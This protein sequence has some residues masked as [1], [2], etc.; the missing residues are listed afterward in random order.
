MADSF[1]GSFVREHAQMVAQYRRMADC[2]MVQFVI[3]RL[4]LVIGSAALP[5]LTTL[6]N[7]SRAIAAA[8][9]WR[10]WSASTRN[11]NGARSGRI[12]APRRS[13]W[14]LKREYLRQGEIIAR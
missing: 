9:G 13:R 4:G 3:V 8:V 7:R 10:R 14:S 2:A 12:S 1:E 11:S 5:A 6:E